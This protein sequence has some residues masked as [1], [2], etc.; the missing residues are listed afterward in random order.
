MCGIFALLYNEP[1]DDKLIE[2]IQKAFMLGKK[3]GPE[4][5]IFLNHKESSF[6]L[7]TLSK[8]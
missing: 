6:I 2:N 1:P 5:S 3:R 4:S 8:K 7:F